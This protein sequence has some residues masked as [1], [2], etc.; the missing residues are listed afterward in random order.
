MSAYIPIK[1]KKLQL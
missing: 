1:Q